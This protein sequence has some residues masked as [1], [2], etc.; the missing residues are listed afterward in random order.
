MSNISYSAVILN[1]DSRNL[2]LKVFKAMIPE[3]WEIVAH[4]MTIKLGALDPDTQPKKDFE[5]GKAIQLN[6]EDYAINDKVMAVGVSGYETDNVKAHITLAVNKKTGGK[7][8]M[9]NQLTDWKKLG[10]PITLTGYVAE[11]EYK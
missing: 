4:H 1:D 5:T 10:F 8:V 2:L 3:G 6:V 11:I 7:P 9:S